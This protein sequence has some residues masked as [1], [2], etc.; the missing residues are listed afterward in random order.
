VDGD[1][2][3][4]LA[5]HL[6]RV[7]RELAAIRRQIT[8]LSPGPVTPGPLADFPADVRWGVGVYET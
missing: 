4:L 6:L 7:E 8:A 3:K 1:A 5:A 2:A